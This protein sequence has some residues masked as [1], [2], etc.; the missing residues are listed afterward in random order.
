VFTVAFGDRIAMAW[1]DTT[2]HVRVRLF[3]PTAGTWGAELATPLAAETAPQ[4]LWDGVA[5]NIFAQQAGRLR[6]SA[7]TRADLTDLTA[8]ALVAGDVR[9]P[10][11]QYHAAA[12][13]GRIHVAFTLGREPVGPVM[14]TTS[15]T[16]RGA[17]S[18]WAAPSNT[19]LRT[20]RPPRIGS[21]YENLLVVATDAQGIVRYA[22]KDPNAAG[23]DLT[24]RSDADAWLQ[25]GQPVDGGQTQPL[26]MLALL[27]FNSDL[28]L[29]ANGTSGWI[30]NLGRSVFRNLMTAKWGVQLRW[31][32]IGGGLLRRPGLF[33]VGNET[34]AVGDVDGDRK[35]DYIVFHRARV[36][37]DGTAPVYVLKGSTVSNTPRELW[38]PF[39]SLPGEI[40]AVGDFNG[41]GKD[42]IVT[43]TQ[44]AQ[45]FSD[46]SLI[47]PAVVWVATSD[48]TRFRQSQIWHRSFAAKTERPLVGD[49]DGDSVADIVSFGSFPEPHT[50]HLITRVARSNRSSFGASEV[51][52]LD[53]VAPWQTPLVG[54]FNG[55]GKDDIVIFSKQPEAAGPSP[56]WV[57]LSD[58][59]SF[60]TPSVWQRDFSPGTER[61]A[62]ADVDMDGKDDIISFVSDRP[63]SPAGPGAAVVAFSNGSSFGRPVVWA[64]EM[65]HAADRPFV[66]NVN[67]N[68]LN[69]ITNM[70]ADTARHAVGIAVLRVDGAVTGGSGLF[71][72]PYVVGAPWENYKWFTEKGVGVALYP[73][74]IYARPGH[75]LQ[76]GYIFA[77]LG[78]AGSGS[79]NVM[80]TSVR[81]GG[82]AGHIQEEMGH[83]LAANCLRQTSDPFN[84]WQSIY[85]TPVAFGGLAANARPGCQEDPTFYSCRP[86]AAE[87]HYF[88]KLLS[89]YR[90]EGNRFRK[91][92]A[93]TGNPA[94]YARR[95]GE[96]QWFKQ[97]WFPGVEFKGG[98][99]QPGGLAINGVQCLPGECAIPPGP[100]PPPDTP[101]TRAECL[102]D[103]RQEFN[104]CIAEG[105][106]PAQ[107]AQLRTQCQAR[108]PRRR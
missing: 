54:D 35:L 58:G 17:P 29:T 91:F 61:P 101:P 36:A 28:Y 37:G 26:D 99:P 55:D 1:Q 71:Q 92:I 93:N 72:I 90:M 42:D 75:C 19:R 76:P 39:F 2:S 46:G 81:S 13:N 22:R 15:L 18:Q 73:E 62:V 34:P 21:I 86:D 74:W 40:P 69:E 80:Q 33:A 64:S 102:A 50:S 67:G 14:Y 32:E 49:F 23:N 65:A 41:D 51:W 4:L 68:R 88:L 70:A 94:V 84:I 60:G 48:G 66:G 10:P 79:A 6:H 56:V 24:G 53:L 43:F 87:E 77:L 78:S 59:T 52:Q 82:R 11:N 100:P 57:S 89:L 106:L 25:A 107:C 9:V 7:A 96:Y 47:G 44:Q 16:P 20:R 27:P 108:C 98:D 45:R 3:D 97:H 83:G 85:A 104:A 103:C 30:V 105:G 12:F 38:H 31:G 5:L 8:P 63:G 95:L